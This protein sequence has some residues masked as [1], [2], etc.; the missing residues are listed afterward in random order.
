MSHRS[1][2]ALKVIRDSSRGVG[3]DV[4]NKGAG[5]APEHNNRGAGPPGAGSS[6]RAEIAYKSRYQKLRPKGL[7]HE[8]LNINIVSYKQGR[9]AVAAAATSS[10]SESSGSCRLGRGGPGRDAA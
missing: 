10:K 9:T 5:G 8:G 1:D 6:S 2:W 7:L 3:V 4:D